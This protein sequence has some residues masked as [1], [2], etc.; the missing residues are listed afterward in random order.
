MAQSQQKVPSVSSAATTSATSAL[1]ASLTQPKDH[2]LA[3]SAALA[4]GYISLRGALPLAEPAGLAGE[5]C[6]TP[7]VC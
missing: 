6:F 1:V 5:W 2:Q 7:K 4:L 3:A